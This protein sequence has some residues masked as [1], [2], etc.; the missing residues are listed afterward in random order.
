MSGYDDADPFAASNGSK[1][2]DVFRAIMPQIMKVLGGLFV[3]TS[4]VHALRRLP[5]VGFCNISFRFPPRRT[6]K[7]FGV[8]REQLRACNTHADAEAR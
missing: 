2:E 5:E 3:P 1:R 4:D 6:V 8:F 7:I